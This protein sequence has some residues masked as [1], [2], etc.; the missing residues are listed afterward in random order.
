MRV[1][2]IGGVP[3]TGKTTLMRSLLKKLGP[4]VNFKLGLVQ[5]HFSTKAGHPS[6]Y[7][8]GLYTDDRTFSGTDRLGMAVQPQAIKFATE[9]CSK[10]ILIFEGDRLFNRSFL[11]AMMTL[12]PDVH[13]IVL[14]AAMDLLHQ[15]YAIRE[16]AQ[17][18]TFLKGRHTKVGSIS[19]WLGSY[20]R[21]QIHS[22]ETP[23]DTERL[24]ERLLSLC[25]R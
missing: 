14:T 18:D 6:I 1:I 9:V 21:L 7:V 20:P 23:E 12:T 16:S 2:A 25:Q 4:S 5:G 15:R 11:Q 22:H 13:V 8:M 10:S 3:G 24:T 17:S 19:T